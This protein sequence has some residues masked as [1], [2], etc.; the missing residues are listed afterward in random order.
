MIFND[1]LMFAA[2]KIV[3]CAESISS[4]SASQTEQIQTVRNRTRA[5]R[6]FLVFIGTLECRKIWNI[7]TNLNRASMLLPAD[8]SL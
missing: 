8:F 6:A 7:G 5:A 2:D 4:L 1:C 3:V